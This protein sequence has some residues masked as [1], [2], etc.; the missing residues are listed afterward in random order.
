MRWTNVH[1]LP[2]LGPWFTGPPEQGRGGPCR[3]IRVTAAPSALSR[4]GWDFP[5]A[6]AQAR[7]II[8]CLT[9]RGE[10]GTASEDR[11]DGAAEDLEEVIALAFVRE[12]S[13]RGLQSIQAQGR[14][15]RR[16]KRLASRG[17]SGVQWVSTGR[18]WVRGLADK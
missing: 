1:R 18:S 3:R 17:R 15:R 14:K 11:R 8:Q 9:S 4:E 16:K 10:E 7:K 5:R 13:R 2:C 6:E 12:N